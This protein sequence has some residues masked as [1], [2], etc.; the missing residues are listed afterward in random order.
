[1]IATPSNLTTKQVNSF[2]RLLV[3]GTEGALNALDAL[4]GLDIESSD[5]CIEI[6][7]AINSE[8]LKDLGSGTLYTVSSAMLGDMQ[9]KILLLLRPSD[10]K[11]LSKAMRPVLDLLFLSGT[12]TDLTALDNQHKDCTQDNDAGSIGEADFDEQMIDTLSEM[13]NIIIGLYTKAI[14]KICDL[15]THYSVPKVLKD[16]DQQ[17]IRQVLSSSEVSGQQHLVIQNEFF[18]MDRSIKLWLVI[19]PTQ[20]SFQK[21]LKKIERQEEYH[22]GQT[23]PASRPLDVANQD[24]PIIT[25]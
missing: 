10:F 19:S 3:D 15:N 21:I 1:M 13:A 16:I 18:V 4:F 9:G 23:G 17:A 25:A 20:K 24:P 2:D 22:Q 5:S 11:Y 6:A 14:Y 7:P 12:D 8:N